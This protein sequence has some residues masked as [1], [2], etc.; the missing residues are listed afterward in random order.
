MATWRSRSAAT[1]V[2]VVSI[3]NNPDQ[4]PHLFETAPSVVREVAAAKLVIYNGADYDPW[5]ARLLDVTPQSAGV[6]RSSPRISMHK[7]AGDNPHLWYDPSTMPTVAK[8]LAAALSAVDPAHVDD[9][10]ARLKTFLA[11]LQ[12]I[13][14]KIAEIRGK[15]AGTAVAAT[16]PVFGYMATALHLTMLERHFQLAVMNNTEPSAGDLA[17]FEGDIKT[18]RVRVAVLQQAGVGQYRAASRR[19]CARRQYS[20][21]R[22]DRDL[23]ARP[24]LP[25]LDAERA[26]RNRDRVRRTFLMNVIELDHATLAIGGR[27]VLV[28]T[29]FAIKSGE[30]IGVLGPNGAGKTT[31]M[32]A[33]L[34]LLPPSAGQLR[35]FG[36]AP[37]RGNPRSATC[38]RCAR[39]CRICACAGSTS[40]PARC[41][42]NAGAC[43]RFGA[44]DRVN[45]QRRRWRRWARA[46]S[47]SVRL[48]ICPAASASVSCWRRRC[49]ASR[50]CCCS[51]SR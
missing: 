11:S 29:S 12:P 34:G 4:D 45:D 32:R 14:D 42:A 21:G 3:L 20:R 49:S 43:R 37:Q 41:T 19:S 47:P 30:F 13:E 33:V 50:G 16:E 9:Y 6:S 39:C 18:H 38:R 31:L 2:S 5:M 26:R 48:R 25:G 36:R 1:R 46:S 8:A 35:V 10:A 7:K 23:S 51:T 27:N 28:D 17:A 44:R 15:Y 24:V 40:S 22:R